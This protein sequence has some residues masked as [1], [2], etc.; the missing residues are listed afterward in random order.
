MTKSQALY[1]IDQIYKKADDE[2]RDITDE[3]MDEIH[4]LADIA[5]GY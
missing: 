2:E 1:G 4:R 5:E 3:E